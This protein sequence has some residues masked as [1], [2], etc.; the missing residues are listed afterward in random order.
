[1]IK[2][3][4]WV[5]K[6]LLAALDQGVYSITG[7]ITS[8]VLARS[9]SP[10]EYGAYTLAFTVLLFIGM[11]QGA[12]VTEP[13]LVYGA[14]KYHGSFGSYFQMLAKRQ[15]V[16]TLGLSCCMLAAVGIAP[17]FFPQPWSGNILGLAVAMPAILLA[18]LVRGAFYVSTNPGG[19]LVNSLIQAMCILGGLSLA[20]IAS[21]MTALVAFLILAAGAL[22]GASLGWYR[23][24][25]SWRSARAPFLEREVLDD[26]WHYGRWLVLTN[27]PGWVVLNGYTMLAGVLLGLSD[28][29]GLRTMQTLVQ[30]VDVM[31]G[32]FG[33]LMLPLLV[34][35]RAEAGSKAVET[36]ISKLCWLFVGLT[37][38]ILGPLLAFGGALTGILYNGRYQ[39]YVWLLPYLIGAQV[40]RS[41]SI[42]LALGLRSFEAS[43]RLLVA[44]MIAA[45]SVAAA[46]YVAVRLGGLH[47]LAFGVI[48]TKMVLGGALFLQ[49]RREFETRAVSRTASLRVIEGIG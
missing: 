20:V 48:T 14:S 49:L 29:A 7:F 27:G 2:R 13:L 3:Q 9:L 33:A 18:W 11:F 31:L 40:L 47:G 34:R 39:E 38:V 12:L 41:G 8:V 32:A 26:H 43:R 36:S 24:R 45:I 28:V 5:K 44:Y 4:N 21:T 46:G 10:A 15:I 35:Q 30:P 17:S 6:G 25:L 22:V 19:A 1:M 37:V 23:M 42:A 16:T